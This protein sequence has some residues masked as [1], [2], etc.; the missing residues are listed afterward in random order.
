MIYSSKPVF[1]PRP[2]GHRSINEAYS[3][4]SEDPVGEVWLLSDLDEMRTEL[5]AGESVLYPS[6]ITIDF[7]GKDLPRFPLL[8]KYIS[9]SEWLSVQVHPD[10]ETAPVMEDE[11]WG[12]SECW[13]FL[14]DS[15]I[16]AGI[17]NRSV[18]LEELRNDDL[19]LIRPSEGDLACLPA[20]IV[21]SLGPGSKLIEIQQTSDITYRLYDW[22]RA[23]ELHLDKAIQVTKANAEPIIVEKMANFSWKYFSLEIANEVSGTALAI[24]LGSKP[25]LYVLIDD[26][27]IFERPTLI[28]YL[29]RFWSE[30]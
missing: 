30:V 1:S 20:G 16:A 28:V 2:W 29:G 12:K 25:E 23:R 9:A 18:R 5:T 13:Y 21:H 3:V 6:D 7:A 10:D 11:P 27:M 22:G 26:R 24:T 15:L 17:K 14:E 19:S 8:I 4:E